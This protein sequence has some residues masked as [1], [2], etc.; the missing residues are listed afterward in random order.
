ML[1]VFYLVVAVQKM[2][3]DFLE[4]GGFFCKIAGSNF[5]LGGVSV[6]GFDWTLSPP[7][8]HEIRNKNI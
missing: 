5:V 1:L 7:F 3:V 8:S 6:R 2:E 4:R